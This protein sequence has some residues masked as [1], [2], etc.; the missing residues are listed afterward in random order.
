MT[1]TMRYQEATLLLIGLLP[2][3]YLA[4]AYPHLPE[5]VPIHYN[6]RGI[7]D[8]FTSKLNLWWIIGGLSA[9]IYLLMRWIPKLDPKKRLGLEDK[10]YFAIRAILGV[11]FSMMFV[12]MVRAAWKEFDFI[13]VFIPLLLLFFFVLGNYMQSLQPNYFVGIR[14]PWN[15]EDDTNWR[16]T[17]RFAGR[18]WMLASLA[19]GVF[20]W[21]S[22]PALFF[23]VF[24]PVILAIACIP[25]FYSYRLYR[26]SQKGDEDLV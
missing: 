2:L 19:L 8:G 7:A 10:K 14:T 20:Y 22:G 12:G 5:K 23:I 16:K 17:H 26:E 24:V 21:W 4:M 1:K 6:S 18:L 11:F 13:L 9:F 25:M 15:L 3:L